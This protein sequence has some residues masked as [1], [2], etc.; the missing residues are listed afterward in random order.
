MTVLHTWS[1]I[2]LDNAVVETVTSVEMKQ[3]AGEGIYVRDTEK[4]HS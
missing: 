1:L 4:E 2:C 3:H